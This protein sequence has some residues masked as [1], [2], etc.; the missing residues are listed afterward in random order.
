VY[1]VKIVSPSKN[2]RFPDCAPQYRTIA[3]QTVRRGFSGQGQ[4]FL[5]QSFHIVYVEI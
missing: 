5:I 2:V 4:W 3:E 1:A